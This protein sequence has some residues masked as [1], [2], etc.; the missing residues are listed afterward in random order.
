MDLQNIE[1]I[2]SEN[3]QKS[4]PLTENGRCE[5]L[6]VNNQAANKFH[7]TKNKTDLLNIEIPDE[8]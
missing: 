7:R 6:R 5:E 1:K 2:K 4:N 8:S 3:L